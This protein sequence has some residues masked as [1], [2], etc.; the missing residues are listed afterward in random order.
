MTT[1][2]VTGLGSKAIPVCYV[3][4]N[5]RLGKQYYSSMQCSQ[6]LPIKE[7]AEAQIEMR[8]RIKISLVP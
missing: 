7:H 1:Q 2:P 3:I 4:A 6:T 8:E 5:N